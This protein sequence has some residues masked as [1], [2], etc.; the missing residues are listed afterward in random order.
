MAK[1]RNCAWCRVPITE[2][3]ERLN[4][5]FGTECKACDICHGYMEMMTGML[6]RRIDEWFRA[7]SSGGSSA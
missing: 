7:K 2:S 6:S 1:K 4:C 3:T 5:P